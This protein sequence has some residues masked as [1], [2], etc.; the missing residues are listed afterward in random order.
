MYYTE[1]KLFMTT[2]PPKTIMNVTNSFQQKRI[3]RE[4]GFEPK[5]NRNPVH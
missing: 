3:S 1:F 2:V 5:N 4:K